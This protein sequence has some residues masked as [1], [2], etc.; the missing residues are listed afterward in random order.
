MLNRSL[1]QS[2]VN[3]KLSGTQTSAFQLLKDIFQGILTGPDQV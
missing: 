1:F 2:L 3:R